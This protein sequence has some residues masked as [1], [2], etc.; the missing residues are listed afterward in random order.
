MA[1]TANNIIIDALKLIGEYAP[2][3][4]PSGDDIAQGLS[5]LNDL[6]LYFSEVGK[7]IP[8]TTDVNF[9]TTPSKAGYIFSKEIGSDITS[10]KLIEIMD[11][12]LLYG[13]IRIPLNQ[14]S[15]DQAFQIVRYPTATTRPTQFFLQQHNLS[16]EIILYYTPDQAYDITLRAKLALDQLELE[17][18]ITN[19]PKS[20]IRY[21]KYKLASELLNYYESNSWNDKKEKELK[22]MENDLLCEFDTDWSVNTSGVLRSRYLGWTKGAMLVG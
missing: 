11:A 6:I 1:I 18:S 21:L 3:E 20:Y 10:P 19:L 13:G 8:F 5:A 16:T 15:H 2:T 7:Y 17:T 22:E 12:Y 4:V 9:T 14:L